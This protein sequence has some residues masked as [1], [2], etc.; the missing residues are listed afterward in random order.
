MYLCH[1]HFRYIAVCDNHLFREQRQKLFVQIMRLPRKMATSTKQQA[2]ILSVGS[3]LLQ[4]KN[5]DVPL[6]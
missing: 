1:M 5:N 6:R 2:G 3:N 4:N